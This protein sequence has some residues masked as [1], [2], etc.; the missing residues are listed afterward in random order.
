M[1]RKVVEEE[2]R[3]GW[4][5]ASQFR[6]LLNTQDQLT[7]KLERGEC[8]NDQR[9]MECMKNY[10]NTMLNSFDNS[11]SILKKIV[12]SVEMEAFSVGQI[13]TNACPSKSRYIHL[14][15]PS[16]FSFLFLHILN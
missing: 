7:E 16:I 10:S 11:I 14:L 1:D 2:L 6:N 4:E 8:S 5:A 12:H 15:F 3:K 13:T 9:R